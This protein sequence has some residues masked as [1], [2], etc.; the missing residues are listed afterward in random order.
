MTRI[1][2]GLLA[3]LGT[4]LSSAC[5]PNQKPT[6]TEREPRFFLSTDFYGREGQTEESGV[7]RKMHRMAAGEPDK[8][9]WYPA[10]STDGRYTVAFPGP[11]NDFTITA[12]AT[13]GT[14]VNSFVLGMET[15]EGVKYTVNSI[16]RP[17]GKFQGSFKD[18]VEKF[19]KGDG[20]KSKKDIELQGIPGAEVNLA[21]KASVAVFRLYKTH[22]K[23]YQLIVKYSAD[24]DEKKVAPNIEK[25]HKSFHF[26][27]DVKK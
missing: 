2:G 6:A 19:E 11:F 13:D 3:C 4:I 27:P 17:D 20:F 26:P 14:L 5:A 7:G 12:K 9:G 21:G 1:V 23:V 24:L 22:D 16:S 18:L 15:P 8:S 10:E 25:F